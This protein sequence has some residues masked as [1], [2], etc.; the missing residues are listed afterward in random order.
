VNVP[1]SWEW[2]DGKCE[3][4]SVPIFPL[5]SGYPFTS[6]TSG[7]RDAY[8][9]RWGENPGNMDSTSYDLLRF[10]LPDAIS[11]AKTIETDEVIKSLEETSIETTMARNFVFSSSHDSMTGHNPNDPNADFML[12]LVFQW[13]DGELVP[14]YPKSVIEEAGA[15]LIF[16]DWLGPWDNIN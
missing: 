4:I 9:T 5:V 10:I 11:R 12:V 15:S 16:P 6:K 8:I 13:Q 1:E 14:V 3:Y 7:A 2:T